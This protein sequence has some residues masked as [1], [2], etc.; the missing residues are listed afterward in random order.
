MDPIKIIVTNSDTTS[1]TS[2]NSHYQLAVNENA[3]DRRDT[4]SFEDNTAYSA[5]NNNADK[6]K[7][8]HRWNLP[9]LKLSTSEQNTY[10]LH[11]NPSNIDQHEEYDSKKPL[12]SPLLGRTF[13]QSQ[14][15]TSLSSAKKVKIIPSPSPSSSRISSKV[16][17][18]N[19][20]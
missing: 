19:V 14:S 20:F 1:I 11:K 8:N 15:T 4:N 5:S 18:K 17:G 13:P 10:K 9:P 16:T 3:G 2:A 7:S 12:L 6:L